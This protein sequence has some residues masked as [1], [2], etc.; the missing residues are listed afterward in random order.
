[1]TTQTNFEEIV[2]ALNLEELPEEEQE[3]ILLDLNELVVKGTLIRLVE[4]MDEKTQK[5]FDELL[6]TE[7]SE[8]VVDEFIQKHVPNADNAVKET[9]AELTND[10]LVATK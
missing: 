10:I 4:G 6:S 1:M 3:E 9:I 8:D 5:K 7:P 2:Q